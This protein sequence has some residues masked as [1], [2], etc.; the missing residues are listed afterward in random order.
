MVDVKKTSWF[1]FQWQ[2]LLVALIYEI[3]DKVILNGI[4]NFT[5][6]SYS[7]TLSQVV[8]NYFTFS[9]LPELVSIFFE[10]LFVSM[11]LVIAAD[12]WKNKPF[13]GENFINT[14]KKKYTK[15]LLYFGIFFLVYVVESVDFLALSLNANI[16]I[17]PYILATLPILVSF[18]LIYTS[19][20]IV[21]TNYGFVESLK[22]GVWLVRKN[23]KYS[24][25]IYIIT[26]LVS[27]IQ[28][29][30]AIIVSNIS[31]GTGNQLILPSWVEIPI[32]LVDAVSVLFNI[33]LVM[34]FYAKISKKL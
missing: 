17:I 19:Y 10:S 13:N 2:A 33:S 27:T 8:E 14:F 15:L 24:V 20:I 1:L 23:F 11:I 32:I 34:G 26:I 30:P 16:N 9:I 21:N 4:F 29:L 5:F 22:K 7:P 25:L 18:F 6:S 3:L 28:I 12:F 31:L